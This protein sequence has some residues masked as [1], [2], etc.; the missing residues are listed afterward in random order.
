[1]IVVVDDITSS[2][3]FRAAKMGSFCGVHENFVT[4][5]GFNHAVMPSK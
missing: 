4:I 3:P 2:T 1:M 5:A